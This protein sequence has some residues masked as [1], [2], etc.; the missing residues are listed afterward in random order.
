MKTILLYT[1]LL[2]SIGSAI[3]QVTPLTPAE[4][5]VLDVN[6]VEA[7]IV[8][9]NNKHWDILGQGDPKYRVPKTGQAS[10]NF[11]N[12]IWIAGLDN[13]NQLHVSANTYRQ[14]GADFWPGPLD[15]TN[16]NAYIGAAFNKIWKV[17][18]NDIQQ[19][20]T[21]YNNGSVTANTYTPSIDMQNY[22]AKGTGNYMRNMA[23]FY[24]ANNDG[25]YN[26]M[27]GDY[28]I[29][30]GHQQILSIYNDK[31]A[32]HTESGGL[33]M[34]IE[35]HERSYAYYDPNLPDSM[36]AVNYTTFYHYTIFNRSNNFYNN[37]YI[38]DWSDGDL[39]GYLDDYIGCDTVNGF[40]YMYNAKPN[41]PDTGG[42]FGY[43]NKPPVSSHALIKTNCSADGIDNDH[44][45]TID[46]PGE[47]FT[48]DKV[49]FYQNNIGGLNP[50]T[51][52]PNIA[53]HYYNYMRS[54]WKDNSPLKASGLGYA[55][56]NTLLPVADY[57]Y[58]GN[59]QTQSGW[60]ESG[61]GNLPGDRRFIMSSGPFN[62]P[63]NTKIEWSY[64]IVFSQDT[65]VGNT[66]TKFNT[67]VQ[68]DVRNARL[69]DQQHSNP[70]CTPAIITSVNE[71]ANEL[72]AGVYPNPGK[73]ILN[74]A[75][76]QNLNNGTVVFR[77]ILGTVIKTDVINDGSQ[78]KVNVSDLKSGI[79]FITISQDEKS[80]TEKW[81]KQD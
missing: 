49:M 74:I 40:A 11:A 63:P 34:G 79:Y 43:G 37:V 13:N 42:F 70:L 35:I 62:F 20:V 55:P 23:P 44:D 7:L 81:V 4:Q 75:L 41:D 46:E 72:K 50:A 71:A 25:Q 1:T 58:P 65:A 32:N 45:G 5:R 17:S 3:A 9:R 33:P 51:T 28:P 31:L 59:P 15:T 61:S 24:D 77:N 27:H 60:T 66:I 78:L 10:A 38:S 29:I 56:T 57:A 73:D 22:P 26:Y 53:N 76:N 80:F 54:I 19:F 52:N 12:S 8:G 39:G 47:T 18:C 21:A 16:A 30:K 69:Y 36:K 2:L 64:A 68:R 14:N 48:M 6:Q 67:L